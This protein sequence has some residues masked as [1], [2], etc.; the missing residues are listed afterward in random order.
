MLLVLN[1]PLI[2]LWVKVLDTPGRCSTSAI[3]VFAT[4]GVYSYLRLVSTELMVAYA[5]GVL[6]FPHAALRL[7]HRAR[8]AG[9][10][11]RAAD[12]AAAA[13]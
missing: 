8:G 7:P 11:P 12:G 1:L 2:R 10:D 4:L 3:L 5:I 13:P 9:R 6:G